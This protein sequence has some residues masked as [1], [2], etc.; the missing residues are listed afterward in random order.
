MRCAGDEIDL[1]TR[2]VARVHEATFR[3]T[4]KPGYVEF[5]AIRLLIGSVLPAYARP[6]VP[7]KAEPLEVFEDPID[8]AVHH[9]G[10]VE[11]FVADD[12]GAPFAFREDVRGQR[13]PR[14]SEMKITCG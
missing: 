10:R 4:S 1:G 5:R 14:S 12:E 7:C 3:K 9:A 6:F 13:C 11:I 2:A 8:G